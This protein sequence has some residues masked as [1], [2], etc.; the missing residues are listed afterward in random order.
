MIVCKL[1]NYESMLHISGINNRL[2]MMF[3]Y[4]VY[5]IKFMFSNIIIQVVVNNKIKY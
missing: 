2:L 1:L 3:N 5:S 4:D